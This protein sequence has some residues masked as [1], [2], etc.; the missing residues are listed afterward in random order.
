MEAGLP[1]WEWGGV[2]VS[3]ESLFSTP[4]GTNFK[5]P[6]GTYLPLEA[7]LWGLLRPSQGSPSA[8]AT[9]AP[10]FHVLFKSSC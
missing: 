7:M 6:M 10:W 3:P 8:S 4:L 5:K 1:A 9:G 2:S